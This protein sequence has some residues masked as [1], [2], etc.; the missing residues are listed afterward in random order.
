MRLAFKSIATMACM[1][2]A[3]IGSQ[4]EF[5]NF[6]EAPQC[7]SEYY[8]SCGIDDECCAPMA[9]WNGG[10]PYHCQ[11][12]CWWDWQCKTKEMKEKYGDLTCVQTDIAG[13]CR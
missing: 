3:S 12:S 6:E 7:L 10:D 5:F 2:T 4:I 1:L 8:A 9:C 13:F 11:V